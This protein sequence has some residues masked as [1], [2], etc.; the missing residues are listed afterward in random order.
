[1]TIALFRTKIFDIILYQNILTVVLLHVSYPGSMQG[2]TSGGIHVSVLYTDYLINEQRHICT[3]F[4]FQ[5][6]LAKEKQID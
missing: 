1:M 5:N 2:L 4:C 6:Q 3:G